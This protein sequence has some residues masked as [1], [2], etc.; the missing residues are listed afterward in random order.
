VE[1][2]RALLDS[3]P[4]LIIL[5]LNSRACK[6]LEAIR[7]IRAD[8]RFAGTQLLG[9]FS[10]VQVE[11][12]ATAREAGCGTILPRSRFSA[13]LAKILAGEPQGHDSGAPA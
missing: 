3:V 4:D 11:L 12:E 10:H 8:P 13:G 2:E 6:P 9:F 1:L 7:R 5:D